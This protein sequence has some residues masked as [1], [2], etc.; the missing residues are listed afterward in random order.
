[1]RTRRPPVPVPITHLDADGAG[2]GVDPRGRAW[3]VRG[4]PPGAVVLAAGRPKDA[5]RAGLVEAAPDAVPPPCPAFL[6]CGGCTFQEVPLARQRVEKHRAVAELLAP[7]GGVDH[8]IVGA[9]EGYGWR[10]KAELSFGAER[11]FLR[12]DDVETGREGLW[13]GYHPPG[14]FDRVVDLDACPLLTAPM[15][16]VYARAR[17]DLRASPFPAWDPARH[18]G[19]WRYLGLR[20]GEE[21]VLASLHTASPPEGA[22]AWIGAYAPRWGAAGVSWY[23][24]DARGDTVGT[25]RRAVVCGVEAVTARLGGLRFRLS[26]TAFF[27]VN[28]EGA[29]RLVD[30]VRGWL[31]GGGVLWDLYCGAGALGLVAADRFEEVVGI[32]LNPRAAEDATRNAAA[33]GIPHARFVAGAVEALVDTLPVPDAVVVDPPRAGLHPRALAT[34]T[35]VPARTLVYVACRPA[36]LLR[37]GKALLEAG[38][39]CTDRVAVDLFPQT[40]HLEVVSRWERAPRQL[41]PGR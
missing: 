36:S 34:L 33:N 18:V 31:G 9:E 17:A 39:R 35:A 25:E 11:H 23:V 38:W 19:F 12:G 13:L 16:A 8:G 28:R 37:D 4:A 2:V 30:R 15:N 6:T 21:G 29:E 3:K 7:L 10:N 41:N 26:P 1:M 24:S 27:Q 20:E 22:E 14:R 5:F 32:E 40:V